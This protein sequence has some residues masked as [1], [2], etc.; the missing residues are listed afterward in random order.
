MDRS[1]NVD[2]AYR[3]VMQPR[4]ADAQERPHSDLPRQENL[5]SRL[6][7]ELTADAAAT[8]V[9]TIGGDRA[10]LHARTLTQVGNVLLERA[11]EIRD[12]VREADR[13]AAEEED[14]SEDAQITAD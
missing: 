4:V 13:R 3:Q 10:I 7:D 6:S 12:A 1:G 14:D 2:R 11:R 8:V 5:L 9:R